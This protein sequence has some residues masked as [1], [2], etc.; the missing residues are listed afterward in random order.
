MHTNQA[1]KKKQKLPNGKLLHMGSAASEGVDAA[2]LPPSSPLPSP[3]SLPPP[4]L[5][6]HVHRIYWESTKAKN[7]FQ[8]QQEGDVW[9]G[10][11]K[12]IALL[13][14]ANTTDTSYLEILEGNTIKEDSLTKYQTFAFHKKCQILAFALH[15]AQ[16]NMPM[17][18]WEK[19]WETAI[20]YA[21]QMGVKIMKH[22][23]TV[24]KWYSH[25]CV[26]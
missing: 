12:Q 26:Q 23:E 6:Q 22:M 9:E 10:V 15:N 2:S 8:L 14:H 3:L 18:I 4:L 1:T 21:T 7:L 13:T 24:T 20:I 16:Q 11:G 5:P 17:W 25:F 19:C